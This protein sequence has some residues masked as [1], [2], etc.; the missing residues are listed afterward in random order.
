MPHFECMI[1][2]DEGICIKFGKRLGL[3]KK[4]SNISYS[5]IH[6][7]TKISEN[8]IKNTV[9][10][11]VNIGLLH[12]E[13]Y[14]KLFGVNDCD[15]LDYNAPIPDRNTLQKNISDY[16]K[17]IGFKTSDNFKRNG[18]SYVVEEFIQKF[19]FP[20]PL[21][22]VQIRDKLNEAESTLYKTNDISRVLNHLAEEGIIFRIDTGNSKKPKYSK[23]D[24]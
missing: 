20:E 12:V 5:K 23:L 24:K 8:H 15:M 3:F 18:P 14:A 19:Q 1:G 17:R 4:Q 16:F 13:V 10:G 7:A 21:E 6:Y 22:P 9:A 11:K 2:M